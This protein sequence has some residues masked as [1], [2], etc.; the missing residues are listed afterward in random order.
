V[1]KADVASAQ[2]S[3]SIDASRPPDAGSS[4]DAGDALDSG[5]ACEL[6][7]AVALGS[8]QGDCV[9]VDQRC[10]DGRC[11]PV[12]CQGEFTCFEGSVYRCVDRGTARSLYLRCDAQTQVCE[13]SGGEV[14]CVDAC[15][16]NQ[17][18]CNGNLLTTC[19]ADGRSFAPGGTGCAAT[20]QVCDPVDAACAPKVCEPHTTFCKGGDVYECVRAGAA[21]LLFTHCQTSEFCRQDVTSAYC[22]SDI[23]TPGRPYSCEGTVASLCSSDGSGADP[24]AQTDCSMLFNEVCSFGSCTPCGPGVHAS[25]NDC[26][27]DICP[28][29]QPVCYENRIT[30]CNARGTDFKAGGTDCAGSGEICDATLS[31]ASEAVD[32]LGTTSCASYDVSAIGVAELYRVDSSRHL[33]RV[34]VFFGVTGTSSLTWFVYESS[35][36][37]HFTRIFGLT[38]PVVGSGGDMLVDSGQISV[39]LS[40]GNQYIIGVQSSPGVSTCR[41]EDDGYGVTWMTSFGEHLTQAY[42]FDL[43]PDMLTYG[44]TSPARHHFQRLTTIP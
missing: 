32:T 21:D 16:P 15:T 23:C 5:I 7:D 18:A 35:D 30:T 29:E 36:E 20:D 42:F 3:G 19:Q 37:N 22:I 12:I 1:Q 43:P 11:K 4:D 14:T 34:E 24:A 39:Q 27:P 31:C 33:T 40:A 38:A 41:E 8:G 17:P 25:G 44:R 26:V 6:A 9:E 10:I 28:K 2:D 13:E